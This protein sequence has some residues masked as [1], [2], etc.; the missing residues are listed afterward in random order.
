MR[1][2]KNLQLMTSRLSICGHTKYY[3][4]KHTSNTQQVAWLARCHKV[5]QTANWGWCPAAAH[6]QQLP[7]DQLEKTPCKR[8][9]CAHCPVMSAP[10]V[11]K[12]ICADS[13]AVVGTAAQSPREL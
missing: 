1:R 10:L 9:G 4:R 13:V 3:R 6:I 5:N 7:L 12:L 2:F 8:R 11:V